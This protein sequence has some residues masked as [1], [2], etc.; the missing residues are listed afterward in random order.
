MTVAPL[1]PQEEILAV[2]GI[3]IRP[4]RLGIGHRRHRRML[5]PFERDAEPVQQIEHGLLKSG[6]SCLWLKA[7]GLR[8]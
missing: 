8:P 4:V 6:H 5:V 2:R 7:W 1:V 3:D